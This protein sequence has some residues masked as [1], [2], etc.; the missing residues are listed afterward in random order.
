VHLVALPLVDDRAERHRARRGV[1]DREVRRLLG[2]RRHVVVVDL[3]G[4]K[5]TAGGHA[6]LALVQERAP[7]AGRGGARHVGV[8]Q[9]D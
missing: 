1:A 7:R 4:D 3:V 8:V 9:D 5:V 6:D 2:Q